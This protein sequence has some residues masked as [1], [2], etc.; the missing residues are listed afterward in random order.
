MVIIAIK[1]NHMGMATILDDV[2]SKYSFP[3]WK[4]V[5]NCC[6][7]CPNVDLPIQES[8]KHHWNTC[9]TISFHI[10][11]LIVGFSFHW[12]L[13]LYEK[14]YVSCICI[15]FLLCHPQNYTQEKILL[16]W[17][18]LFLI[19]TQVS[20]VQTYKTNEYIIG[21]YYCGN[22][23]REAFKRCRVFK[24]VF[25]CC[26]YSGRAVASFVHQIKS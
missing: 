9:P 16:W 5:L 3:H 11:H 7:S 2:A 22:T 4:H 8:D 15:I 21:M 20:K 6:A 10:Y 23:R 14:K 1:K 26:D 19:S 24:D 18:H 25:C 12:I 17:S 13:P